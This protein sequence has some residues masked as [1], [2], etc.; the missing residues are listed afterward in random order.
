MF[1]FLKKTIPSSEFG[2]WVLRRAAP[3][4]SNGAC[5][6]LAWGFPSYDASRG[7]TPVF[8]ANGV[9]PASAEL[10]IRLYS[11]CILQGVFKQYSLSQRRSMVD[12][13]MSAIQETPA[14][15]E[16]EKTFSELESVFDGRYKFEPRVASLNDSGRQNF[17]AVPAAH[18]FISKYLI[19]RFML[20]NIPNNKGYFEKFGFYTSTIGTSLATAHR[21]INSLES[22]V[23][24]GS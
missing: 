9:P 17:L 19:D 8:E 1:G 16:F 20:S 22:V 13:A 15:Y 21:A 11:H 24:I 5:L 6:S 7:W 2:L 4:I 10:Y 14:G 18:V 3:S 23:K 12:G